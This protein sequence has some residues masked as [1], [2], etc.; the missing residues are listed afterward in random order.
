MSDFTIGVDFGTQSVRAI[1]VRCSDGTTISEST[2][3]YPHGVL[4]RSLP[5]GT[6]LPGPDWAL[7]DPNDYMTG[8]IHVVH[9]AVAKSGL[10]PEQIGAIAIAATACTLL[11]VNKD[12]V[13]LCCLDEYRSRPQAWC[14]LWKHHRAQPYATQLTETALLMKQDFLAN[15]GGKIS[16]EW[17]VPKVMEVFDQDREVYNASDRFM[18]FSDWL[19]GGMVGNPDVQN[20]SIA[21]YKALWSATDGYP[22]DKYLAAVALQVPE[23]VHDKLRGTM[24]LA[25][26]CVGTLTKE[27]AHKLGL[28]TSSRVG[29][30]HTD[31]HASA[32]GS[33][34]ADEGDYVFI[35]GTSS[36]GHL[37]TRRQEKVSGVTGA[38]PDGLLRGYTCYSAGQACVGDMLEW[39]IKNSVPSAVKEA[40]AS[41][42]LSL[43]AYLEREAS[44]QKPGECG[45]VTLDWFNG[46]RS[47]L[48]NAALSGI[49]VGLTMETTPIDI[50]RSMLE[51]IAFGHREIVDNFTSSNLSIKRIVICGGIAHKNNLLLQIMSDV[52]GRPLEV[53]A[54]PQATALGAAICAATA[55]GADNGG[56]ESLPEA[57]HQMKA[58]CLKTIPPNLENTKAYERIYNHYHQLYNIFGRQYSGIM[59]DLRVK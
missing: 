32:Y 56:Y 54:E 50:Y 20:G 11:P 38:L 18:Q 41:S 42:G 27:A 58:G 24:Y 48:V 13:P 37:I 59:E 12:L 53:S 46:N 6:P 57:I 43:H 36:C 19:T 30:A 26:D 22:C 14:K 17:A 8:L 25:G 3:A 16:S 45:L 28:S 51:A 33:G 31:A 34:I 1:V 2:F 5:D 21:A 9:N 7:A 40:A 10:A 47:T 4:D 23:I 55:L 15:Y 35:L 52:L 29:M 39:F 49:T 44:K